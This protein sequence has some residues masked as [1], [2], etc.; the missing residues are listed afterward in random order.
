MFSEGKKVKVY[1]RSAYSCLL[2]GWTYNYFTHYLPT[3]KNRKV[4][5]GLW[6]LVYKGYKS[7]SRHIMSVVC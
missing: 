2:Q 7:F 6:S 5:H 3:Y 4:E 1:R